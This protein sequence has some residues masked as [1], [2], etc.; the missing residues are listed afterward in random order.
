MT[1]NT[2][3]G[4]Y[5]GSQYQQVNI[6]MNG[7]DATGWADGGVF[8]LDPNKV[9][10]TSSSDSLV[11]G[12]SGAAVDLFMRDISTGVT[13]RISYNPALGE[14]NGRSFGG[15][16]SLDGDHV[17]FT[18]LATNLINN[19]TTMLY[20]DLY[21]KDL[22][23]GDVSLVSSDSTGI[24]GNLGGRNGEFIGLLDYVLF[25]SVSNNLVAGDAQ[26]DRDIFAKNLVTGNVTIVSNAMVNGLA[27]EAHDLN[28]SSDGTL[29][30]IQYATSNFD[31]LIEVTNLATSQTIT[32]SEG[33]GGAVVD[34]DLLLGQN[35]FSADNSKIVF[36]SDATNLTSQTLA[37]E[38]HIYVRDLNTGVTELVSSDSN[39][40]I[41]N[42][43][44]TKAAISNDGTKIA[45]ITEADNLSSMDNNGVADIYVKD[46]TT[47]IT[48]L[49]TLTQNRES[50]D[51][52]TSEVAFSADG[53][54]LV[55]TTDANNI[56][57]AQTND[58]TSE[59]F[60]VDLVQMHQ[61]DASDDSYTGDA[62]ANWVRS[63]GGQDM[64]SGLD[65]DDTLEGGAGRDTLDG[66]NNEDAL[67]GGAGAD[68]LRGGDHNDT[69]N[70]GAGDDIL[71]GNAGNDFLSG[72]AGRDVMRGG[73]GEDVF[74][75]A[76]LN[77]SMATQPDRILDFTQGLDMLD[78]SGIAEISS[79]NDLIQMQIG[80]N[81]YIQGVSA[82][83]DFGL[84][85]DGVHFINTDDFIFI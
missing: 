50:F 23:T 32:V 5:V 26:G 10:F 56:T 14:A 69:L 46:L 55:I 40:A 6:D 83:S 66:G 71:R 58:L 64:I 15:V 53:N 52:A 72:G 79:M 81:T 24:Q 85:L 76:A 44:S 20:F 42:A 63:M 48:S 34:G 59:V 19:D 74:H 61:G 38:D 57:D 65:G 30:A 62:Q 37:A 12:D 3:T 16:A 27:V 67:F 68:L 28:T 25:S 77:E 70:G 8:T 80:G 18:S 41:A 47:G 17:L 35:S 21:M 49:V 39:G 78:V 7:N 4:I 43:E 2:N 31:Y 45:F 51:A 33:F 36:I 11:A 13:E 1:I 9:I 82:A 84:R 75:F 29:V 54:R 22:T 73:S 60:V